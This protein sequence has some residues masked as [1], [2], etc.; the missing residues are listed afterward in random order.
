MIQCFML[1]ED[2][3]IP[4]C[5]YNLVSKFIIDTSQ[6]NSFL[7]WKHKEKGFIMEKKRGFRKISITSF[8]QDAIDLR[9]LCEKDKEMLIAANL[10]WSK[11]DELLMKTEELIPLSRKLLQCR[12]DCKYEVSC[13]QKFARECYNLRSK[14][15]NALNNSFELA[16]LKK[17]IPGMSRKKAYTDISQDLMDLAVMAERFIFKNPGIFPDTQMVTKARSNSVL[18]R[19]MEVK[20]K[21]LFDS[22][23]VLQDECFE[24]CRSL[25]AVMKTIRAAA[26][27]AFYDNPIR[28]KA[29]ATK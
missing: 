27:I 19:K 21:K 18:L 16:E 8:I 24:K 29:Y 7:L 17:K 5:F 2:S 23:S 25:N 9:A 3:Y 26:K 28:R 15:R 11:Y 4:E 22:R 6:N 20:K 13:L 14:L 1:S 12:E 10:P